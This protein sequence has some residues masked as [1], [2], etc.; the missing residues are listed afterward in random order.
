M[1]EMKKKGYTYQQIGD[2][3]GMSRQA[4]HQ[5]ISLVIDKPKQKPDIHKRL[6]NAINEIRRYSFNN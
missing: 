5:K 3:F 2:V 6:I 1:I 4:V